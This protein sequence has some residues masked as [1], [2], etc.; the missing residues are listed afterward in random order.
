MGRATA[1]IFAF[2]LAVALPPLIAFAVVDVLADDVIARVGMGTT[3][4][5]AAGVTAVWAAIVAVGA[6]RILGGETRRMVELAERGVGEHHDDGAAG[7]AVQRLSAALDERNRQIAELA[8]QS[9]SAP[10]SMDAP[11]VARAMVDA[12]RSI[13]GDP[14]WTLAV[15]GSIDDAT[16]PT[17]AYAPDGEPAPLGEVHRWAA[18]LEPEAPYVPGVRHATGPW[19]AF[20]VV[21]VAASDE[22]RA[23][24]LA[25][26]EGRAAPSRSER[27]LL[28]L[29]GQH[30]GMAIEHALLY[31]RVRAQADELNRLAALQADF[32]RGVS[33]DLQTPLTSIRALAEE[34]HASD[35]LPAAAT[36]DLDAI[37]HQ[38]DRLRR[39][40]GQLLA[41]SRL[42]SGVLTPRSDVF[43]AEPIIERTW[44][45][46]RATDRSFH[47][48]TDGPPHLVIGDPD[49]F[50]QALWAVL[51]N[52]VKYS[53]P[54]STIAV[55]VAPADG[56][57]LAIA[58][59][60]EGRGMSEA[61]V[62]QA[63]DQ[64]FRSADARDAAPDG[65]GIGLYTARGL[66]R[67][68][69]GD[70]AVSSGLGAG[71][72]MTLMLPAEAA[73]SVEG[74]AA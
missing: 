53:P 41:M 57:Q 27:E 39:M 67:A 24:L 1:R 12:A 62:H 42:E 28:G 26:R 7:E 23:A 29:L 64:F 32:L 69:G 22:L 9:R 31:A 3:L 54:G 71:T 38:A 50:E 10:I 47:M 68:M 55:R 56:S 14:T 59:T 40:V 6:S 18:T 44:G 43:R 60:D 51:D 15:L 72:T 52:A 25:P 2:L 16:L 66:L 46:L 48:V 36:D 30:A 4:L 45:A 65:S 19:G 74:G 20:V 49:R 5:I 63:F 35:G 8:G 33:H 70:I 13:T 21:E 58:V 34:V 37:V 11:A 17:G 61:T 73:E